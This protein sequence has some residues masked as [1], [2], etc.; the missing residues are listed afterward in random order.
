MVR[1]Q[2]YCKDCSVCSAHETNSAT[3]QDKEQLQV[4]VYNNAINYALQ[5]GV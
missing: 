3:K 2:H 1:Q 4:S 5:I